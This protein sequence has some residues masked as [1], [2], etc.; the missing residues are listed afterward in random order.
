MIEIF[1]ITSLFLLILAGLA[2]R[3]FIPNLYS[4]MTPAAGSLAWGFFWFCFG[5]IGRSFF[6][7]WLRVLAGEHWLTV[8]N[9][10]GGLHANVAFDL[11]MIFGLYLIL[12]ARL[13]A[14]PEEERGKW[15]IITACTYT[16]PFRLK[17]ILRR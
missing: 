2:A 13:L 8:R 3:A 14:I 5:G 16:E 15:N 10:V 4:Q 9:A 1:H 17:H 7:A 12:R 11:A 6:W